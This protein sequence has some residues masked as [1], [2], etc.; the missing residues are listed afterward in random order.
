MAVTP[1]SRHA[2]AVLLAVLAVL[3]LSAG[4]PAARAITID[5]DSTTATEIGGDGVIGPGDTFSLS[6]T[7]HSSDPGGLTGVS[8]TLTSTTPGVTIGQG[9]SA[10]PD[11]AFGVPTA[12]STPFQATLPANAECGTN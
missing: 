1:R 7:I 6:E 3:A 5:H 2:R 11:L 4:A 8:G 10:Y 9:T 12:N